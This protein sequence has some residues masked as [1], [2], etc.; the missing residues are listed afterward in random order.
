MAT[1]VD[2]TLVSLTQFQVWAQTVNRKVTAGTAGEVLQ[3][4]RAAQDVAEMY[5]GRRFF[6]HKITE[7]WKTWENV[8]V[9]GERFQAMYTRQYPVVE[10]D[11]TGLS[12]YTKDHPDTPRRVYASTATP[13]DNEFVYYAGYKR[14][15]QILANDLQDMTEPTTL[16][17][18][19]ILPDDCPDDLLSAICEAALLMLGRVAQNHVAHGGVELEQ[20]GVA[21]T[22]ASRLPRSEARAIFTERI[23]HYRHISGGF[24]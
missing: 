16:S 5:A 7:D 6:I 12:I 22:T 8:N 17:G 14:N 18:L 11:T 20:V 9:G 3:S 24:A 15:G 19:D 21:V 23:P 2:S 10:I 1:I 13:T 4:L